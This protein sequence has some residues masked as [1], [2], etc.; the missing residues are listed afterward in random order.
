MTDK[1]PTLSVDKAGSVRVGQMHVPL[2]QIVEAHRQGHP[3]EAI[4]ARFPGLTTE[5]FQ[6]AIDYHLA[7]GAD[8]ISRGPI[9]RDAHWRK[10]NATAEEDLGTDTPPNEP[11][12]GNA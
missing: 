1:V 2:D 6:A 3:P 9:Q 7:E 12:A 10:W 11:I 4:L 8:A 5:E